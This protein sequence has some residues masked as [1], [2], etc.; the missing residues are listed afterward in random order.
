MIVLLSTSWF[1]ALLSVF[2]LIGS[3]VKRVRNGEVSSDMMHHANRMVGD[4]LSRIGHKIL[5]LIA[6][7]IAWSMDVLLIPLGRKVLVLVRAT[8][9][10]IFGRY[11]RPKGKA[12]SFFLKY[13]AEERASSSNDENKS[14]SK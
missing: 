7:M 11:A 10:R 6:R 3:E 2:L 4:L 12:S 1:L 14:S 8:I 9:N 13:I 5:R